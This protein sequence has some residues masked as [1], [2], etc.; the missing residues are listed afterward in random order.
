MPQ[1]PKTCYNF[2]QLAKA[3]KYNNNLFHRLVPGFMVR[4]Q[5]FELHPDFTDLCDR[6]K[7]V[8]QQG[9]AQ[10]G[11][12]VGAH[13]SVTSTT[14]EMPPSMTVEAL[15]RWRTRDLV[16]MVL[17]STLPSARRR[18][19][20]RNTQS[21]ANS[22]G[23]KMFW[24]RSRHCPLS[25]ARSDQPNRS[26]SR[27]SSCKPILTYVCPNDALIATPH[28]SYQDPFEEYKQR[29][30]RKRARKAEVQVVRTKEAEEK[31]KDDINWFGVKVGSDKSGPGAVGGGIGKYL[32]LNGNAKRPLNT[33]AS[34]SPA[35]AAPEEPKKKRRIGFGDFEG[36]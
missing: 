4:V 36:W 15:W 17:N 8:T 11:S 14:S 33:I 34:P 1:A 10:V 3:G 35:P 6:S 18:I 24:M 32:N 25:P 20:T 27:R 9:P 12:H 29:E 23:A 21:S 31:A 28:A 30:E 22:L 13:R 5:S 19:S 16:R 26:G 2:L 7:Q